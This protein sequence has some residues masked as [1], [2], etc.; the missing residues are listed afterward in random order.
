MSHHHDHGHHH[1]DAATPLRALLAALA[2]TS[3]VFVAELVGGLISGSVALLADAMHMLSD[4]AGL[5]IAVIAVVAGSKAASRRA[6]FGYRRAE[7]LAALV[8]AASVIMISLFIVVE[9]VKRLREASIVEPDTM[10]IIAVIGLLANALSAWILSRHRGDSINVEGALLHVLVDMLGSVAVIVASLVIRFTGFMAADVIASLIIAAMVL[11]RAV[12]LLT[13][14]AKVLLEQ[15][16]DG[17]DEAKVE[18]ALLRVP[19]VRDTHDIHLWSL[20]GVSVIATAHLVLENDAD[21]GRTL[22]AAQH[23]LAK[24]GIDHSTIQLERPEHAT[25]ESI[26]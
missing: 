13:Q 18:P 4:A 10:L 8:N 1:A 14:S 15:V 24:L 12:Q 3:T 25:H 17:F 7:V 20:D 11:P 5:I 21:A 9:A 6:T 22:D 16:P 19:G 26:C 2:I 23:A